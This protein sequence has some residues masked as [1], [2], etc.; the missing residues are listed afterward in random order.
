MCVCYTCAKHNKENVVYEPR[1]CKPAYSLFPSL[2]LEQS[3]LLQKWVT[4]KKTA[5]DTF[6]AAR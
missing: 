4:A 6:K 5:G 1:P 2:H 3:I